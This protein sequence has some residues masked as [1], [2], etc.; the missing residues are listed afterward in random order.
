MEKI[1]DDRWMGIEETANYL[2]VNKDTSRNWIKKDT[3]IPAHRI[4]KLWKFKKSELD[5]WVKSGQ[6]SID[7]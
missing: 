4:G 6:A 5:I 3:G 2:G 7:D 1:I